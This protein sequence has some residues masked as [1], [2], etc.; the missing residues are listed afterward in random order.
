MDAKELLNGKKTDGIV[1]FL[2]SKR[3]IAAMAG[4]AFTVLAAWKGIDIDAELRVAVVADIWKITSTLIAGF[5]LSDTFGKGKTAVEMR[6]AALGLLKSGMN[7]F[8]AVS[9]PKDTSGDAPPRG[10]GPTPTGTV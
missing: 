7:I 6:G 5:S 9:G 10:D 4:I 2:T 8:A 1:G 3:A